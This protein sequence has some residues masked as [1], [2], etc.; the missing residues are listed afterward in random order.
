[1][2][3][4]RNQTVYQASY[5]ARNRERL[6]AEQKRWRDSPAGQRHKFGRLLARVGI[7]AHDWAIAWRDQQGKCAG[8][9]CQLDGGQHTHM[10]HS[11]AT[12]RFRGLLCSACNLALGKLA[13]KPAT[14]RRLAAYLEA[15]GG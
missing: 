7:T 2:A 10:D 6:C 3:R 1:M 4:I 8:C 15:T 9:L 13:D 5:Y 12:G 11:H 14:L